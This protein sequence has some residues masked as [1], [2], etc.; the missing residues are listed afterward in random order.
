M[1]TRLPLPLLLILLLLTV[2]APSADEKEDGTPAGHS[3]HG[4]A[5]ND[6]PRQRAYLMDHCGKI[7]FPCSSK[8]E[9]VKAFV[10]QGVGQLHGFWWYEA[11]RS[12]RAAAA[13]DPK[14]GIAYWG[15]AL[16]NRRRADRA[17]AFIALA[18]AQK[19]HASDHE[20]AYIDA[21]ADYLQAPAS[22]EKARRQSFIDGLQKIVDTYPEDLE[23][24]ALL[25]VEL[26]NSARWIK[27]DR[28]RADTLIEAVLTAQPLHPANHYKIHVWDGRRTAAKALGA[29]AR[30][31]QSAPAVAHMWHMPGHIYSALARYADAAWQQEASAR[32]DHAYLMRDRVLPDQVFNYA[33]NNEWLVRN[34]MI[35]GRVEEA[36]ALARNM[37]QLPRHPRYN[38]LRRTS[39][40][41][42][43]GRRRMFEVLEYYEMW[44]ELIEM[45]SGTFLQPT[46]FASEQARRL[47]ARAL[48]Y[49]MLKKYRNAKKEMRELI[50][51]KPEIEKLMAEAEAEAAKEAKA[52]GKSDKAIED[53][54]KKAAKPYRGL[55]EMIDSAVVEMTCYFL[56]A[57]RRPADAI[58]ELKKTKTMPL[59][60]KARF[61]M[62]AGKNDE[63]RKLAAEN[64][65]KQPGRVQPL[66]NQVDILWR[67][68]DFEGAKQAFVELRKLS[69]HIDRLDTPVFKRLAPIA[70]KMRLPRDWRIKPEVP[71]DVGER[72]DLDTIGPFR[73]TSYKADGWE[74]PDHNNKPLTLDKFR[75]GKPCLVI[76]YLGHGCLHC[77]EQLNAFKPHTKAF[78]KLGVKIIAVATDSVPELAS[79]LGVS[80]YPFKL[81]SGDA[82]G[83]KTFKQ[84]RCWDDFEDKPLHGTFLLDRAGRVRWQDIGYEPFTD[85]KFLLTETK[86]LLGQ[87]LLVK[88]DK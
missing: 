42:Y 73:W 56:V 37:I 17:K 8:V 47:R 85:T 46:D 4:D 54:R 64:V 66:A 44:D 15:M 28:E 41:A 50:A 81:V 87:G 55:I 74:L 78:A 29:A 11:E 21:L 10:I 40:S 25:A 57:M 1:H 71:S 67:S 23:A 5:F 43:Y 26:W 9:G 82:D 79:S 27:L 45:T 76:F 61:Y 83:F 49:T 31:G 65:K 7:D 70:R 6:G 22:D 77:V 60:R 32:C 58:K 30:C 75:K 39:G 20:K 3:D 18:V 62:V 14:C 19:E 13:R 35:V 72:P 24:K 63:A 52:D 88:G 69:G 51:K 59:E 12:F 80:D 68:G 86:R 34:L 36:M 48:A 16:A 33:H 2:S 84:W 53:A 38:T